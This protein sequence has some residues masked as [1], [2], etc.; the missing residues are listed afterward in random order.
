MK[1]STICN[2]D[3]I[4][5]FKRHLTSK[6]F[7]I[8]CHFNSN[9][10]KILNKDCLNGKRRSSYVFFCD[11]N[12]IGNAVFATLL[13]KSVTVYPTTQ[14]EGGCTIW[15]LGTHWFREA[16][17]TN[18]QRFVIHGCTLHSL[19]GEIYLAWRSSGYRNAIYQQRH[20]SGTKGRSSA[21]AFGLAGQIEPVTAGRWDETNG[22]K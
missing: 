4:T 6:S 20:K 15:V 10:Q 9:Y 1:I 8:F 2:F 12:S 16:Q 19:F 21:V 17:T 14:S 11:H 7:C 22:R 18:D 5:K 3:D 13:K